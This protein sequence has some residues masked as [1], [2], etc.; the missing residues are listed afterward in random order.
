[1]SRFTHQPFARFGAIITTDTALVDELRTVPTSAKVLQ[2]RI[3]DIARWTPFDSGGSITSI[4]IFEPEI[5]GKSLQVLKE[6]APT[7]KPA[8]IEA[9]TGRPKFVVL[10]NDF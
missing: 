2:A 6:I 7:V 1:M 8:S 4:T 5:G 9:V 3:A 10:C